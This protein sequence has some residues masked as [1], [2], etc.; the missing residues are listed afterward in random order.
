MARL[1]FGTCVDKLAG[2]HSFNS[3]EILSTVLVSVLVSENNF[4]KRSAASGVVNDVPDNSLDVPAR[5]LANA[6][7][8]N[9]TKLTR[10]VRHSPRF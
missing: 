8:A 10:D 6:R 1:T 9:A 3:D 7:I 4:G 2:V 5:R